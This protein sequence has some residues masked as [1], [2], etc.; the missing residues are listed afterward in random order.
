MK[1]L[2]NSCTRNLETQGQGTVQ[3]C[4]QRIVGGREVGGIRLAS[5]DEQQHRNRDEMKQR[6]N[7]AAAF[8]M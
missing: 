5:S 6:S 1:S 8:K 3:S 7:T 4:M 2:V